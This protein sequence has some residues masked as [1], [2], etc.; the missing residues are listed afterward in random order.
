MTQNPFG[1]GFDMNAMLAQA[2]QMQQQMESLQ[3]EL[4]EMAFEGTASGVSLTLNGSGEVTG[5]AFAP[6]ALDGVDAEDLGDLV[7]AA[8]RDA[9]ARVDAK[10]Q[11]LFGPLTQG[12]GGLGGLGV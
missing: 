9:R 5:V 4:A 6:T 1:E 12:L 11:E 7:V 3:Q 8:Y 2:Q 10:T